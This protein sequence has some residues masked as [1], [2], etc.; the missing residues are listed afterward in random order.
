MKYWWPVLQVWPESQSLGTVISCEWIRNLRINPTCSVKFDFVPLLSLN[1]KS[2]N[3]KVTNVY[4]F[5]HNNLLLKVAPIYISFFILISIL[6]VETA[7]Y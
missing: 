4:I 6:S 7:A 3:R 1:N 5:Y 2:T